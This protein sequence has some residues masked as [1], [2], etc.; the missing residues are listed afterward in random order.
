MFLKSKHNI[1][2][3]PAEL[4]LERGI[5]HAAATTGNGATVTLHNSGKTRPTKYLLEMCYIKGTLVLDTI[6][7]ENKAHKGIKRTYNSAG[8]NR[9]LDDLQELSEQEHDGSVENTDK[10]F[11]CLGLMYWDRS[12]DD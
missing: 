9:A 1:H 2:I 4:L 5:K 10:Y 12:M 6:S 7:R 11:R 8:L 3:F